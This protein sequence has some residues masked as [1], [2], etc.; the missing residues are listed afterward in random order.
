MKTALL[1]LVHGSPRP[2]ANDVMFRVVEVVR[3]RQIFDMVEV[4]FLE[5]NAPLISDAIDACV[6]Q[7]ATEITAVPYFLHTGTHV[8]DDLPALL[9]DA[10]VRH[11]FVTFKL[12]R[13]LG[14]SP[15][16][17]DILLERAQER[18]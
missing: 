4:G 6:S 16:L 10:Q 7:G 17:A 1:V 8:A 3:E 12:G 5:C 11:S 2:D 14:A 9:D 13:Y 18:L 15:I